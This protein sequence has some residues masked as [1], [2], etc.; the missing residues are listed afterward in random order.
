MS[1]GTIHT[2]RTVASLHQLAAKIMHVALD[3]SFCP[4]RYFYGCTDPL[5]ENFDPASDFDDNTCSYTV[6]L[7]VA[8]FPL[9]TVLSVEPS[10]LNLQG[11]RKRVEVVCWFHSRTRLS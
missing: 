11:A 10:E 6:E 9:P 4:P 5:A 7:P 3:R 1:L 2:A 8:V